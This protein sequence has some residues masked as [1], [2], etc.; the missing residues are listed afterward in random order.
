MVAV[1]VPAVQKCEVVLHPW[2]SF[3][4]VAFVRVTS[5]RV[6][7]V[8]VTSVRVTSILSYIRKKVDFSLYAL[9]VSDSH[10]SGNFTVYGSGLELL[11]CT[12]RHEGALADHVFL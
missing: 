11:L 9:T 4:R 7:S 12:F 3:I 10:K 8:R 2:V 5:V 6:T 1:L